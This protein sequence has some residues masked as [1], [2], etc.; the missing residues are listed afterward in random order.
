M[1]NDTSDDVYEDPDN[2][3][4]DSGQVN[5]AKEIPDYQ[6]ANPSQSIFTPEREPEG[7]RGPVEVQAVDGNTTA[8]DEPGSET[9]REIRRGGDEGDI[10]ADHLADVVPP[11]DGRGETA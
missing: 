4:T 5:G 2:I 10:D 1:A 8:V 6:K 3:L 9:I 11:E 7:G